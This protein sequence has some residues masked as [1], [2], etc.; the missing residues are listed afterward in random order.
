MVKIKKTISLSF[1]AIINNNI[2]IYLILF[3]V[4]P[5]IKD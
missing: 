5:N 3:K 2:Y 1:A 4:Q